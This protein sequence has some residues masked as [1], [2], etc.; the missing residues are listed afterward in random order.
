MKSNWLLTTS[1]A[2]ARSNA[3]ALCR[4]SYTLASTPGSSS[5][6]RGASACSRAVVRESA[7]ANNVTSWPRATRPSAWGDVNDGGEPGG[8]PSA[9]ARRGSEYAE[10]LR[11][12]RA[13]GLLD[14]RLGYYRARIALTVALFAAGW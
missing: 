6:P 3:A 10:L 11:L 8:S 1:N 14:R 4:P 13:E 7:V 12:V 2:P 9:P 5:Y